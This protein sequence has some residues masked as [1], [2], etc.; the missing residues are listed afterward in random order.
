MKKVRFSAKDLT[1]ISTHDEQGSNYNGSQE[2]WR[3]VMATLAYAVTAHKSQGLTLGTVYL[4]LFKIFG[5]GV[6]H[7]MCTRTPWIDNMDFVGVPPVDVLTAIHHND[8]TGQ[9]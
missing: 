9:V 7:A 4:S 5:F 3:Q 6:P 2:H 8:E 1:L